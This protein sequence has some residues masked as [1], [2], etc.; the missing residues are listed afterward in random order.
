MIE[1]VTDTTAKLQ[2]KLGTVV[3]KL[4]NTET[5]IQE[6]LDSFVKSQFEIEKELDDLKVT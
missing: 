1:T 3:A 4:T 5:K 6:K 2:E